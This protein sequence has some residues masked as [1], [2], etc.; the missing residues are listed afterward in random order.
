MEIS[1]KI[2][3]WESLIINIGGGKGY[4]APRG[5]IKIHARLTLAVKGTRKALGGSPG[6]RSETKE[7]GEKKDSCE[8]QPPVI[9]R[10]N[11][12]KKGLDRNLA[13]WKGCVPSSIIRIGAQKDEG[14]CTGPSRENEGSKAREEK[15]TQ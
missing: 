8:S 2:V 7:L 3:G 14:N 13:A 15:K 4:E 9:A 12:K 11:E 10:G 1:E 5:W 6:G